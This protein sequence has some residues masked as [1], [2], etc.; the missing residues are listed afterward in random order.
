MEQYWFIYDIYFFL[1]FY[2][3]THIP[4]FLLTPILIVSSKKVIWHLLNCFFEV[5]KTFKKSLRWIKGIYFFKEENF[6]YLIS[7]RTGTNT[8]ESRTF[9]L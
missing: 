7:I 5:I 6:P 4:T 1:W 2:T 3:Y 9:K 8:L